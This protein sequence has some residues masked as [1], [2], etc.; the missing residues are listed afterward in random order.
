MKTK[1]KTAKTK[2]APAADAPAAPIAFVLES[3]PAGGYIN[4]TESGIV[5]DDKTP[6]DVW[7]EEGRQLATETKLSMFRLGDWFVFGEKHFPKN[8]KDAITA[9]G[10]QYGTL[11][12]I[13]SVVRRFPEGKRFPALSFE[14][15][16]LLAPVK[17]DG[18][19]AEIA[20]KAATEKLSAAAMRQIVPKSEPKAPKKGAASDKAAEKKDKKMREDLQ[21]ILAYLSDMPTRFLVNWTTT[22]AEMVEIGEGIAGRANATPKNP[23]PPVTKKKK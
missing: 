1:T 15:H 9:T 19:V 23:A 14:H 17:D 7:T 10:L 4:K 18:A 21:T 16:R 2:T 13:A 5:F 6:L 8:Y 3:P 11:R 20:T 12:N 22:A